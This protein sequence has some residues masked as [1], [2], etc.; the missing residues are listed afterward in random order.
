MALE[1]G[2]FFYAQ[3]LIACSDSRLSHF[4]IPFCTYMGWCALRRCVLSL[5]SLFCS[6]PLQ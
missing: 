6:H 2:P 4:D 5:Y 3:K 1:I